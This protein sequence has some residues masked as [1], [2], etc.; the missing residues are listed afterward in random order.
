MNKEKLLERTSEEFVEFLENEGAL[1]DYLKNF[2]K[3]LWDKCSPAAP[4]GYIIKAFHWVYSSE[5]DIY[6]YNLHTKWR[7][8]VQNGNMKRDAHYEEL[9]DLGAEDVVHQGVGEGDANLPDEK[10]MVNKPPHY[11]LWEGTEAFDIMKKVLT[12]EELKGYLKG[13]VL[14][15]RLRAGNKDNTQQ[16]IDKA[17]WYQKKLNS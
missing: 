2:N 15:Y 10:D 11:E 4:L 8:I 5:G 12:P 16:D 6:W 1:K 13:N 3:D 14:K 9:C 7:D 17:N